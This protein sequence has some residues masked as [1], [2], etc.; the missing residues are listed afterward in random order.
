MSINVEAIRA[1]FMTDRQKKIDAELKDEN[2]ALKTE[3]NNTGD[4]PK[5]PK[6]TKQPPKGK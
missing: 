3:E 2:P 6:A 4:E 1:K 5:A